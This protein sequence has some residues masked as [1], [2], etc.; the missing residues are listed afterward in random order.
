MLEAI[1]LGHSVCRV[2][3]HVGRNSDLVVRRI[4]NDTMGILSDERTGA[5]LCHRLAALP[6]IAATRLDLALLIRHLAFVIRHLAFAIRLFE[7]REKEEG[8]GDI[9]DIDRLRGERASRTCT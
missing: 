4:L 8:K 7:R 6:F 1:A 2:R 9:T 5:S 3:S